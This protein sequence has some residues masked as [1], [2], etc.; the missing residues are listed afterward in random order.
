MFTMPVYGGV[1]YVNG[2]RCTCHHLWSS[3][4]STEQLGQSC[5]SVRKL[6]RHQTTS[7]VT[8]LAV[9]RATSC[10]QDSG[11]D[12]QGAVVINNRISA[13]SDQLVFVQTPQSSSARYCLL[14]E[15]ELYLQ[16]GH[17]TSW[18]HT[19]GTHCHLTLDPIKQYKSLKKHF[20][21]HLQTVLCYQRLCIL[22]RTLMRYINY[23]AT[24][25]LS[26]V[27][28]VFVCLCV[29]VS[30]TLR[31]CIK[32]AKRRITQITPHDSPLTLVFWHQ[33]SLRNLKGITPYG[34]EKCRWGGL[35]FVTFDEN[36]AITRKRYKIDI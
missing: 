30:V 25:M 1:V 36:R 28:A 17:S 9:N 20:R 23:R 13:W 22:C 33:S 29:C 3:A 16:G 8:P 11:I 32:T 15:H 26:A 12:V 35:K 24:A 7:A 34:G 27:Y 6:K 18:L 10:V 14:Q 31:Y 2:V 21:T 19:L 4:T 5:L